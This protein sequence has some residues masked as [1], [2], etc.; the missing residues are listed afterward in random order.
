MMIENADFT[1]LDR[2]FVTIMDKV[3]ENYEQGKKTFVFIYYAGHGEMDVFTFAMLNAE[4][5]AK[6]R[7]PLENQ[8]R[9]LGKI[10]GAYVIGVFDC[11]RTHVHPS[12][13]GNEIKSDN[14]GPY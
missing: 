5:K 4:T 12:L 2:T 8:I 9:T 10:E 7:F 1:K 6:Y 3:Y 13:R 14:E 11:C